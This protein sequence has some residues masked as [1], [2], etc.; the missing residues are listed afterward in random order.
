VD[1][2][3]FDAEEVFAWGDARGNGDGVSGCDTCQLHISESTCAESVIGMHTFQVPL[4]LSSVESR[5]NL[6]DLGPVGRAVGCCG[7]VH[8]GHVE[9]DRALMV[10]GLVRSERDG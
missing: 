2:E 7:A 9:A 3:L 5:A 6:L 8:F 4:G 10:H 1:A